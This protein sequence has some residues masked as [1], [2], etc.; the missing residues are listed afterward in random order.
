MRRGLRSARGSYAV[1][2]ISSQEPEVIVAARHHSPLIAGL[3]EQPGENFLASDLSALL[4]YTRKA[5]LLDEDEFVR[6]TAKTLEIST[7]S[8]K[9]VTRPIFHI[10]WEAARAAKD[11]HKHF[12]LKEI[13]EQPQALRATLEGRLNHKGRPRLEGLNL[14]DSFLR[15]VK[16]VVIIACGTAAHAG[17]VGRAAIE[18]LCGLPVIVDVAS[19]LQYREVIFDNNTLGIA[20]SQSGETADTLQALRKAQARGTKVLAITNVV[21]SSVAREADGLLALQA[22]PEIGVAS[23]KAY[24]C[25]LTA[26]LLVALYLGQVRG[27]LSEAAGRRFT[28]ELRKLPELAAETLQSSARIRR[29][30]AKYREARRYLYLGRGPHHA[31][32]LEGA[33]KLKELAYL[34]A[35]GYAAGEMK[36]GPLA[37]VEQGVP[38]L[39]VVI[40]GPHYEKML[41]NLQEV[42]ARGGIVIAVGPSGDDRLTTGADHVLPL[43]QTPELLS[44]VLAAIPLQL[45]AYH[46]SDLLGREIDQPRNLAK[47]VTVE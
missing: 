41:G 32:A 13:L 17:L 28:R 22:G 40:P 39:A 24:T 25:Q 23:T 27:T 21:G 11:G 3:G 8:G 2:A 33:L 10:P 12:M 1:A 5:Y 19:E 9:Q 43:P 31:T 26:L 14:R 36:H 45:Y 7:L 6:V 44:P 4:P 18:Q 30:A 35:E 29:L 47:S 20:I 46:L 16:R 15:K 37:L 42:R 34:D 38:V